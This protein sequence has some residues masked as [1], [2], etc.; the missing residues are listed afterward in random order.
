M[1]KTKNKAGKGS[2][3]F[4]LVETIIVVGITAALMGGVTLLFKNIFVDSRQESKATGTIDQ[5]RLITSTF[6]NEIRNA[7]YGVDG[8]FPIVSAN[9][10]GISFFTTYHSNGS[11]NRIDYAQ[12]GGTL[13]KTVAAPTGTPPAYGAGTT[14]IA[15]P[16]AIFPSVSFS[17]YDGSFTGFSTSALTTPWVNRATPAIRNWDAIAYGNGVFVAVADTSTGTN[18]VMKSSDG[19]TWSAVS[20]PPANRQWDGLTFGNGVFVAVSRDGTTTNDVMYSSDGNT[21]HTGNPGGISGVPASSAWR[22]VTYGNGLFVAVASCVSGTCPAKG[23]MTSPDGM[24]WTGRTTS[25]ALAKNWQNVTYGGGLFVA[26][27]TDLVTNNIMTSPDGITWTIRTAPAAHSWYA[28]T[29]G[30]G[31]FV[32]VAHDSAANN[33][34][35]SPDGITWTAQAGASTAQWE[36]VVYA[37]GEFVAVADRGGPGTPGNDIMISPNGINWATMTSPSSNGTTAYNWRAITSGNGLFVAVG[38]GAGSGSASD[39]YIMTAGTS[40]VSTGVYTG[41][42]LSTPVNV[43]LIK[44]VQMSISALKQ[45]S[46]GS[47]DTF[48]VTEGETLRNL[49]TNLGN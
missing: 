16:A 23:I 14:H 2:W 45:D 32:A 22:S 31:I 24:T 6:V 39:Y 44:Y 3:G 41:T 18:E 26:V 5:A 13:N 29:Y 49:K 4:T 38:G 28:V 27:A 40:N 42:S 30:T 12:S 20:T 33:V 47:T 10:A 34:I 17:Y 8:S 46:P 37:N 25:G 15:L 7:T 19:I 43:N 1:E 48:V 36:S 11:V 21:W 35:T 9:S